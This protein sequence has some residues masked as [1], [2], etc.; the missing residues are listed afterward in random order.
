MSL[1]LPVAVAI[2]LSAIFVQTA[3]AQKM[4]LASI[5]CAD[6][7]KTGDPGASNMVTWLQGY[8]TYE[9]D[10]AVVDGDKVKLKESQIKEY[11]AD[12]GDTD[13]VSASAIFMDKKYDASTV[14][15][16]TNPHQ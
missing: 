9:D 3:F 16:S 2:M 7:L 13:L 12:H 1:K 15:S 8:Y 10:P 4:D 11:C 6:F 14:S 5:K